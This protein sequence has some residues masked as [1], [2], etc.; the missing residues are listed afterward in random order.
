M[1]W[2]CF[3]TDL[4]TCAEARNHMKP[5]SWC[6]IWFGNVI[7]SLFETLQ[8]KG[9]VGSK[10]HILVHSLRRLWTGSLLSQVTEYN[11]SQSII[12]LFSGVE[13][14]RHDQKSI[15]LTPSMSKMTTS[16][17]LPSSF[18]IL[19]RTAGMIIQVNKQASIMIAPHNT[20]IYTDTYTHMRS[21]YLNEYYLIIPLLYSTV[22]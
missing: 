1:E 22:A 6:W 12:F 18:L 14:Y 3:A 4:Y 9:I 17:V 5:I 15:V 11:V 2:R 21:C 20:R 8:V 13:Y 10:L 16:H 19:T 7:N